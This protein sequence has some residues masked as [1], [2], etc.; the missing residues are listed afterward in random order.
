LNMSLGK[1]LL[2][3]RE[4][5]ENEGVKTPVAL[6][7]HF[8]TTTIGRWI[9]TIRAQGIREIQVFAPKE[10]VAQVRDYLE[11]IGETNV[12]VSS[13]DELRF[14]TTEGAIIISADYLVHPD[15]TRT[16]IQSNYTV[17]TCK[18]TTVLQRVVSSEHKAVDLDS[19]VEPRHRPACV[20]AGDLKASKA[21]IV[22]WSQKGIHLT[23]MLNAPLENF[24]VKSIGEI[25]WITPNRITMLVNLLALAVIYL[26]LNGYFFLGSVVAYIAAIFDGVDGKLARVRGRFTKLGHLEHSLDALW[27]QSVY[28]SL[29]IGLGTHGYGVQALVTGIIFLVIDSFTRHVF[30][31]FALITGRSLK[32]YSDFDRKFAVIDGR[33]NFYLI[34]FLVSAVLGN[35]MNGL[36]LSIAHASLTAVIY[37]SRSIQH[38][39]RLDREK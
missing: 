25:K 34:Y 10:A 27:E 1:I 36:F 4:I 16:F 19:F 37:L 11:K 12:D 28:A 29:V 35:P 21:T 26:F 6:L 13:I 3:F 31:Q 33:R 15:A 32:T 14:K 9:Q 18:Q 24:V 39:S 5:I 7:S 22:M 30:N 2:V 20:Y 23:S 38:L 8:G 17:G